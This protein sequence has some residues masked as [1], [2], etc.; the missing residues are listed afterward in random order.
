LGRRSVKPAILPGERSDILAVTVCRPGC[1]DKFGTGYA[2][3]IN[4][5]SATGDSPTGMVAIIVLVAVLITDTF[6]ENW[7]AT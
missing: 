3:Y 5:P 1:S 6:L 4:I 2:G 7:F